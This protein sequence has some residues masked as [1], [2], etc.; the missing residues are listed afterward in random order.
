MKFTTIAV[1]VLTT[2]IPL[3]WAG[4]QQIIIRLREPLRA[5]SIKVQVPE[6]TN[7]RGETRDLET[8]LELGVQPKKETA[9]NHP[10]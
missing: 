3:S 7:G 2:C 5:E 6:L 1:L 8:K 9:K 4:K 10:K